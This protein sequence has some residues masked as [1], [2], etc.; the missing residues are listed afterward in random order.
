MFL[1]AEEHSSD[2]GRKGAEHSP[3]TVFHLLILV[4]SPDSLRTAHA[5]FSSDRSCGRG[6]VSPFPDEQT[7]V[8]KGT[9]CA[10]GAS[11]GTTLIPSFDTVAPTWSV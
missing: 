1:A 7:V 2:L 10:I 9:P 6:V 11:A 8:T 3:G 4:A 5:Y